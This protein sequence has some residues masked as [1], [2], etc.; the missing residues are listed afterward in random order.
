MMKG[1]GRGMDRKREGRMKRKGKEG[2]RREERGGG[3]EG[4]KQ[5]GTAVRV[6]RA[7]MSVI[8]PVSP[9]DDCFRD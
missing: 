6:G 4:K 5:R 1:R 2:K 8:Y 7:V 9:S 3:T